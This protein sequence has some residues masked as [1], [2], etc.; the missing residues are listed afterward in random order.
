MEE[1]KKEEHNDEERRASIS[2]SSM[3]VMVVVVVM[4]VAV[5][6]VVVVIIVVVMVVVVRLVSW[7]CGAPGLMEQL[8]IPIIPKW[9][10]VTE[11]P[12]ARGANACRG[13]VID[14]VR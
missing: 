10:R 2:S 8:S 6:V 14:E 13:R 1:K 3:V 9:Q 12:M 11:S 7:S 4:V 5:V